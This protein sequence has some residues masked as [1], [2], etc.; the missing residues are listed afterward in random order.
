MVKYIIHNECFNIDL[1]NS[2]MVCGEPLHCMFNLSGLYSFY[3]KCAIIVSSKQWTHF[4][5]DV[6]LLIQKEQDPEVA[7]CAIIARDYY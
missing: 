4:T 2:R 1:D 5:Q 6:P 3:R 7:Y